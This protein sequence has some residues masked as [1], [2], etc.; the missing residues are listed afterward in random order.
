M[1]LRLIFKIVFSEYGFKVNFQMA[2]NS[3][4][5]YKLELFTYLI[6]IF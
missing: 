4:S 5:L 3:S 6:E 1:V 2:E